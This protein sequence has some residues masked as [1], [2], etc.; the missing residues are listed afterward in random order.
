MIKINLLVDEEYIEE[1]MNQLP[2]GKVVVIEENFEDNKLALENVVDDY[3]QNKEQFIPYYD[4]MKNISSWFK[5][6]GFE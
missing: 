2:K 1:F 4:S 3:S 6:K 5:E